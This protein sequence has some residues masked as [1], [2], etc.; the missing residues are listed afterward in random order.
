MNVSEVNGFAKAIGIVE[1]DFCA[2][3]VEPVALAIMRVNCAVD[4]TG[5]MKVGEL[6][7]LQ[8]S[9]KFR[10]PGL[11]EKLF[12]APQAS[13][14]CT[15]GILPGRLIPLFCRGISLFRRVHALAINFVV[16]P[17]EAEICGE[18]IRAGMHMADHALAGGDRTRE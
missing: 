13:G 7:G 1:I 18:H 6:S 16:P 15:F 10:A 5:A 4:P 12:I 3:L 11:I 17:S 9:V 8:L 14:G 2:I